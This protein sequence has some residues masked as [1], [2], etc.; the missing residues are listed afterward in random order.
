V[1]ITSDH[2]D[3]LTYE[4][5]RLLPAALLPR[6]EGETWLVRETPLETDLA[7]PWSVASAGT[8][9][10]IPLYPYLVASLEPASAIA[11]GGKLAATF[12]AGALFEA[13][14]NGVQPVRLH[15]SV[16]HPVQELP[17]HLRFWSGFALLVRNH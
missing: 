5:Q 8:H 15:M 14:G 10:R 1:L 6:S 7:N 11:L 16:G 17:A 9:V 3:I 13:L 4:A 12:L 2:L